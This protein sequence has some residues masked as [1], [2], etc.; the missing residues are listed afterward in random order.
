MCEAADFSTTSNKLCNRIYQ[1]SVLIITQTS[2]VPQLK[3]L[4]MEQIFLCAFAGFEEFFNHKWISQ[5]LKWQM[6]SGC[7]SYDDINCSSHMNGLGA[8]SLSLFG[9]VLAGTLT[10]SKDD[11]FSLT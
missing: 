3:D 9:R 4:F 8:A 11:D 2:Q 5:V 7:F 6:T 10:S 1:E